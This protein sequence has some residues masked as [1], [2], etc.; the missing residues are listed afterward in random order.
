MYSDWLVIFISKYLSEPSTLFL[1]TNIGKINFNATYVFKTM[2]D[3][4]TTIIDS[5]M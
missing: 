1:K 2:Y 5:N 3:N 4:N